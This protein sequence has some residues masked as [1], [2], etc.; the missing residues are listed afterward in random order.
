MERYFKK[1]EVYIDRAE[2][3]TDQFVSDLINSPKGGIRVL[4]L[5]FPMESLE[6]WQL[7]QRIVALLYHCHWSA[8]EIRP[9]MTVTQIL[10]CR[11]TTQ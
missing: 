5:G 9:V 2:M 1:L 8:P 10:K 6:I 7:M 4:N 3:L 11:H